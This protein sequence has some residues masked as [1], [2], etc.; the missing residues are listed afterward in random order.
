MTNERRALAAVTVAYLSLVGFIWALAFGLGDLLDWLNMPKSIR[1]EVAVAILAY[2]INRAAVRY[3]KKKA[4]AAAFDE[5]TK[6]KASVR[7]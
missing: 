6:T 7:P 1:H 2:S 3:G 4:L 5:A